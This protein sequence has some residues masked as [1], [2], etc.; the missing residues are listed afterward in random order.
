MSKPKVLI[1]TQKLNELA[2][3]LDLLAEIARKATGDHEAAATG[4]VDMDGWPTLIRGLEYVKDQMIK[5]AGPA[6]KVHL[7]EPAALLLPDQSIEK[8]KT[9]RKRKTVKVATQALQ[10]AESKANYDS[11]PRKKARGP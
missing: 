4:G 5:I 10:A 9:N 2:D 8:T 6:S 7:L 1:P 3:F 11:K